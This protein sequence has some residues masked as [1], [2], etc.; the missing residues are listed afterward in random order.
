V[1]LGSVDPAG[2]R[3]STL[4]TGKP[5]FASSPDPR[6]SVLEHRLKPDDPATTGLDQ[7]CA[8]QAPVPQ[9]LQNKGLQGPF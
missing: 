1:V 9:P 5:G 8:A 3:W 7:G 6:R 4:L 2:D